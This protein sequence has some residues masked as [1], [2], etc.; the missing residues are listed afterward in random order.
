M[1]VR[2][3]VWV[4]SPV[5]LAL[6]V[7]M[8]LSALY[9]LQYDL[10]LFSVNLSLC[11]ISVVV[12]LV[13]EHQFRSHVS[14]A[15]KAA[16]NVLTAEEYTALENFSMPV[17]VTGEEGD[18]V[19]ANKAFLKDVSNRRAVWGDNI[20]RFLYPK[21][22][23]QVCEDNGTSVRCG[24]RE[25]TVYALKTRH[26]YVLY[27]VDDTYYKAINREFNDR[28]PCVCMLAFDNRSEL[29][30]DNTGIEDA[31]IASEVEAVL[32]RWAVDMG[33]FL[34][35][36]SGGDRYVMMTD[37]AHVAAA[38][39]KRFEVLD[40][41]R[42]IRSTEN[43]SATISVGIGRGALT[44]AESEHWA[45][46]ALEM[47][48]G[49]GGDQVAVKQKNDTYEFFGGL[50]KGVEKRDKVRTRVI[51]ATL[52]DQIRQS[53]TVFIMGHR[54]GDLDCMGAAVGMWSTVTKACRCQGYIVM[55]RDQTLATPI[56]EKLEKANPDHRI[57]LEPEEAMPMMTGRSLMIVVDTHSPTFVES[58]DLLHA[59]PKV[60]VID[61]HRMMVRHID[62][63]VVF[64]LE[65]YAS[66]ASEMVTELCQYMGSGSHLTQV[67]AEALMAGIVLDTK[68]FVLKTGVRTFEASAYLR[69]R[70]ADTV[71]VKRMFASNIDSYKTKTRLVSNAEIY[72]ECAITCCEEALPDL[73]VTAAQ[74]AD[75]LLAIQGVCASF[76]IFPAGRELNVSAR[77]LGDINVQVIMEK[78]GGGGHMTMAAT[79]LRDMSLDQVKAELKRV[80]DENLAQADARRKD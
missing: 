44:L 21:T 48:L 75:E 61:H 80:L 46:Q 56:V 54:F 51:A 17:T 24:S 34:K 63:A 14:S 58:P 10:V 71:E 65:P 55:R 45:R 18:L 28:R 52:S 7:A 9:S 32:R 60:V 12:V 40:E 25:F 22:L 41:V 5:Y 2:R 6:S 29:S 72:K 66:S 15:M 30:N 8:L 70:G 1:K 35:R 62:N 36:M 4:S 13:S 73:R 16:Q 31:R 49:R 64:Y 38:K 79:Q 77:S 11:V 26:G 68:N 20:M 67:E 19:W 76:V 78:M 69:R 3:K 74:A 39:E 57:F 47:A 53:D 27:F 59:A 43:R 37:E 42:R 50:S 23:R 33:G